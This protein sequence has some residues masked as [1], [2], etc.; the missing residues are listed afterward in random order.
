MLESPF[1]ALDPLIA[2]SVFPLIQK[3]QI[4]LPFVIIPARNDLL[5]LIFKS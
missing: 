1:S 3:R 2:M 5:I 4:Y